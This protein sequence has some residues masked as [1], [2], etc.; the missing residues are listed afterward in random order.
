MIFTLIYI[1]LNIF[2]FNSFILRNGFIKLS[3]IKI[4]LLSNI[5]IDLTDIKKNASVSLELP[6]YISQLARDIFLEIQI[7]A[8]V[9]FLA[10]NSHVFYLSIIFHLIPLT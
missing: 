7:Q 4:P 3:R 5:V 1:L 10:Y 6:L 8:L 9:K 2:I